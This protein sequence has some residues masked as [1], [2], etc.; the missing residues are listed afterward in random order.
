M[1]RTND[2]EFVA[3]LLKDIRELSIQQAALSDQSKKEKARLQSEIG[4]K[5]RQCLT[6]VERYFR[7]TLRPLLAKRF[8]DKGLQ[9]PPSEQE[10]FSN[11]KVFRFTELVSDFFLE[12]LEKC[13][14][15]FW[16][17]GSAIELRNYASTVISNDIRDELRRNRKQSPLGEA[18]VRD[19]FEAQLAADVES[20]FK[21]DGVSDY[22]VEALEIIDVWA[23]S[24]E[25]LVRTYGIA[26][27][28]RFVAGMTLEEIAKDLATSVATADRRVKSGLEKLKEQLHSKIGFTI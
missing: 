23:A 3:N 18:T 2:A 13:E 20:R 17:K 14:D 1:N 6:L 5:R 25:E 4:S 16:K 26:L 24:H 22:L 12:V 28:L 8:P 11:D 15:P 9:S 27:R 21:N 7:E 19:T 10:L